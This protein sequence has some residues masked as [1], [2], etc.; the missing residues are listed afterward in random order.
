MVP[1]LITSGVEPPNVDRVQNDSGTQCYYNYF[2]MEDTRY[3]LALMTRI[4]IRGMKFLEE[5]SRHKNLINLV[6]VAMDEN[7]HYID[8]LEKTIDLNLTNASYTALLNHGFTSKMDV[9]VPPGRY[10]IRAVVREGVH[11]KMGSINKMIEVP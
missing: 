8:G 4:N 1:C 11:T 5:D 3:Q 9:K 10:R 7:D 6:V 2:E